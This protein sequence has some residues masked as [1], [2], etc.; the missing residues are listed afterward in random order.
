M[1]KPVRLLMRSSILELS[2]TAPET[3]ATSILNGILAEIWIKIDIPR[4][5]VRH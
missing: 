1:E 5:E 2:E 3:N 4:E